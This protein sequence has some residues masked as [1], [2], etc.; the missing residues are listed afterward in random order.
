VLLAAAVIKACALLTAADVASVQS[1]TPGKVRESTPRRDVSQCLIALPV[2]K[3][4]TLEVMQGARVAQLAGRLRQAAEVESMEAGEDE[5]HAVELVAGL[6][7]EAF[8]ATGGGGLYVRR[9]ATLLRMTI[10]GD[11]NKEAKLSKLRLLAGK[12]LARLPK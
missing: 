11:E 9:G 6:G 10:G 7:D 5:E 1:E 4:V 2:A 3:S 8:W 12:V